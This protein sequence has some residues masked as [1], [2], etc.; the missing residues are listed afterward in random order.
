MT[1]ENNG[2]WPGISQKEGKSGNFHSI[3]LI[4]KK[5]N[6][7]SVFGFFFHGKNKTI[8]FKTFNNFQNISPKLYFFGGGGEG[9]NIK[10]SLI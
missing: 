4:L 2:K 5:K 10:K 3:I 8:F 9:P 6:A 7:K 1:R